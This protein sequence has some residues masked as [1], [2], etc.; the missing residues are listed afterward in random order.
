MKSTSFWNFFETPLPIV[1][2]ILL[3]ENWFKLTWINFFKQFFLS[4]NFRSK[5]VA[6]TSISV[7]RGIIIAQV[8]ISQVFSWI[9]DMLGKFLCNYFHVHEYNYY[10]EHFSYIDAIL[11]MVVMIWEYWY[12]DTYE[13]QIQGVESLLYSSL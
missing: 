11:I 7:W 6:N 1:S 5:D 3:S 13:T 10:M 9:S 12:I 8:V 4:M 2:H